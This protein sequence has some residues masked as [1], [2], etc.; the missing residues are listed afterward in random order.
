MTIVRE[1]I[2]FKRGISSK[3]AL[4]VG[5][6]RLQPTIYTGYSSGWGKD[7]EA[8][9]EK[10]QKEYHFVDNVEYYD[11]FLIDRQLSNFEMHSQF[12]DVVDEEDMA[13]FNVLGQIIGA[14]EFTSGVMMFHVL[15]MDT[16]E[17]KGFDIEDLR[18]I[19]GNGGSS[20]INL[21]NVV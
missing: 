18:V 16:E 19:T 5:N 21:T 2:E 4:N 14:T 11:V 1:N 12:E 8:R 13:K 10:Y 3:R 15:W 9:L 6:A 20:A 17:W 7:K